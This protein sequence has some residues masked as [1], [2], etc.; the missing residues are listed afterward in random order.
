MAHAQEELIRFGEVLSQQK[1]ELLKIL[2]NATDQQRGYLLEAI[3]KFSK[4]AGVEQKNLL[5]QQIV[6]LKQQIVSEI[7]PAY[8]SMLKRELA[9]LS[10]TLANNLSNLVSGAASKQC[11]EGLIFFPDG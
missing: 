6:E 3:A 10:E 11:I 9:L 7:E 4:D 8:R 2:N 1:A 5:T